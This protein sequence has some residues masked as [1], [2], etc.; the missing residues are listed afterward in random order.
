MDATILGITQMERLFAGYESNR[1][2]P[3]PSTGFY[4]HLHVGN[5]LVR[6]N[7]DIYLLADTRSYTY[8]C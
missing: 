8:D 1:W 5:F 4:L 6:D 7:E 2:F 3:K